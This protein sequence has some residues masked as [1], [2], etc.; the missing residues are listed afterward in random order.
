MKVNDK[1]IKQLV[2]DVSEIK[3]D[4]KVINEKV[5]NIDEHMAVQN[6]RLNTHSKAIQAASIERAEIKMR[7]WL[8]MVIGTAVG[9]L[10]GT[11]FGAFIKS[12]VFGG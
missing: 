5:S 6:G 11:V 7:M 3:G 12:F 1:S 4:I 9:G 2:S 10:F 8:V